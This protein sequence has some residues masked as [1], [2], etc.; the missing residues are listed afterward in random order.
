MPTPPL[1]AATVAAAA[2]VAARWT[3]FRRERLQVPGV[4]FAVRL[5]GDL[6]HSS[7][8]GWADVERGVPLRTDHVFRVASHSKTFTATAVLALADAGRLRL[9]DLL[10]QHVPWVAEADP[11]LGR[12]TLRELLGH[13][14][15]VTRDGV[16]GDFWQ[17]DGEFLDADGLREAVGRGGS[18]VPRSSRFKYS[19]IGYS[20]LGLVVE[21]VTGTSYGAHL[22]TVTAPLGLSRTTSDLPAAGEL[23]TGYSAAATGPRR[24]LR[25]PRRRTWPRRRVSA[26]RPRTSRPGSAPTSRAG[27]DRCRSTPAA[28]RSAWSGRPRT[29]PPTGWGSSASCAGTGGSW[30]TPGVSPGSSPRASSTPPTVWR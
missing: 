19:N 10:A 21:A 28:S 30:G 24:Q 12:A 22:A 13:A 16:E 14:A 27:R 11:E 29:T 2:D 26:P 5:H 8:H 3:A 15:G 25:H 18:L 4:Q 6:V 7:A 9:D 1:T 20:L 23:A 17:L